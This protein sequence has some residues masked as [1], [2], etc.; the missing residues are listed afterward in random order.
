ML[1]RYQVA[2]PS[3]SAGSKVRFLCCLWYCL[4][5]HCVHLQPQCC[6]S[7][8]RSHTDRSLLVWVETHLATKIWVTAT[9]QHDMD[10]FGHIWTKLGDLGGQLFHLFRW[11]ERISGRRAEIERDRKGPKGSA[12]AMAFGLEIGHHSEGN[13]QDCRA[14]LYILVASCSHSLSE[15][16]WPGKM[17]FNHE[18]LSKQS[19]MRSTSAKSLRGFNLFQLRRTEKKYAE[20]QRYLPSFREIPERLQKVYDIFRNILQLFLSYFENDTVLYIYIYIDIVVYIYNSIYRIY[21]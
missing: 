19:A 8:H 17:S 11:G 1:K 2:Q 7:F 4:G 18:A 6:H 13:E 5:H 14:G 10:I 3:G 21:W 12:L 16:E 9:C 15:M 20:L